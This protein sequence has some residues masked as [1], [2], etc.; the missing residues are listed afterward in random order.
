MGKTGLGNGAGNWH[1]AG[2]TITGHGASWP[3]CGARPADTVKA[4]GQ[5]ART[6][7][8]AIG[9]FCHAKLDGLAG[10]GYIIIRGK[11]GSIK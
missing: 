4:S 7:Y 2:G 3:A 5:N 8:K 1:G 6:C 11:G 10:I 9:G